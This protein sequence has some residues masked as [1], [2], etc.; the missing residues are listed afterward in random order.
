MTHLTAE[1]WAAFDGYFEKYNPLPKS[2]C[3]KSGERY[4][5]SEIRVKSPIQEKSGKI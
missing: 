5:N 3:M 1:N 2:P 4:N